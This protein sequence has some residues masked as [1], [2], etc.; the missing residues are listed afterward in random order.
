[1]H[2]VRS[3]STRTGPC[4]RMRLAIFAG[5]L[6]LVAGASAWLLRPQTTTGAA[7]RA[8]TVTMAGF[9]PSRLEIPAD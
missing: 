2:A 3:A 4:F 5:I 7:S 8:V 1:M 6:L 9:D